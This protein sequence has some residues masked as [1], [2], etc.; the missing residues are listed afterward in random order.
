MQASWNTAEKAS[1]RNAVDGSP[2]TSPPCDPV[3]TIAPRSVSA[4]TKDA[5]STST[6]AL[7]APGS[8]SVVRASAARSGS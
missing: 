4:L 5:L 7:V 2:P 1:V 6:T 8:S 3:I